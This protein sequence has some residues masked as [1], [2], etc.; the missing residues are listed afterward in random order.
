MTTNSPIEILG[1]KLCPW[2]APAFERLQAARRAQRLGHAWL[3]AG[4]AGIGK[5]NL[6]LVAAHQLLRDAAA[7]PQPLG[8]A[9][10]LAALA[11]RYEPADHAADLHWIHPQEEK[12]TISIEQ[13]R[14]LIDAISLTA[15][16]AAKVVIIE[17]ADAMTAPAANA[18]LKTLEEPAGAAYL[19]L[20]S[21]QPNRLPAT[22]RSRCQRLDI[23]R[24]AP[25][26]LA[27]WLGVT[28]AAAVA[29]AW[30]MTGGAPLRVAQLTSQADSTWNNK[31]RTD[32][33]A[34]SSD[35]RDPMAVADTW[36]K[37]DT[38]L[39]LVWLMHELHAEVRQRVDAEGS[40]AVT[41]RP[42]ATLHNA[43]CLLTLK[44]LFEQYDKAERLLNQLG[45]G[46]NLEL[47]IQALLVGFVVNRGQS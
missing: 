14:D 2:L 3:I 30:Q 25:A 44:T 43:W 47:A 18:L 7:P 19:F 29:D 34:I 32:L 42:D 15:H 31:L 41:V 28:D 5:L 46:V 23:V 40:T 11:A 27:A 12:N 9:E 20:L 37:G 13:I 8:P 17:P 21:S 45:S 38:E 6:A 36:A 24:P 39:A 1:T 26:T 10:A 33:S 22:I 16:G 4:P 35:A